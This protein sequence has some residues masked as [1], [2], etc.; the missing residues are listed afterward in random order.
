MGMSIL[1]LCCFLGK[2]LCWTNYFC[3]YARCTRSVSVGELWFSHISH[4]HTHTHRERGRE[5]PSEKAHMLYLI[6][7][8]DF[9]AYSLVDV[10]GEIDFMLIWQYPL[11]T[12]HILLHFEPVSTWNHRPQKAVQW[13]VVLRQ[14]DMVVDVVG[15]WVGVGHR[16]LQILLLWSLYLLS[17]TMSRRLCSTVRPA[18]LLLLINKQFTFQFHGPWRMVNVVNTCCWYVWF[19]GSVY[20]RVD[21]GHTFLYICHGPLWLLC[22]FESTGT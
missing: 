20:G 8:F 14:M 6:R 2:W 22:V 11:H 13:Q 3:R 7:Q 4:S 10:N 5:W 15:T 21:L 9:Y 19:A 18:D 16:L 12:M 17:R 1:C